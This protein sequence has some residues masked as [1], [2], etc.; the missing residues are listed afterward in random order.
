MSEINEEIIKSGLN[1]ILFSMQKEK[2]A[3]WVE[4]CSREEEYLRQKSREL[5]LSEGDRNT[6]YFHAAA[7][8][9]K[10]N[11][12]IFSIVDHNSGKIINE[13]AE[14]KKVGVNFFKDLLA[15]RN[16]DDSS[17]EDQLSVFLDA[18]PNMISEEDNN[19]LMKPFTMEEIWE[20]VK[21]FPPDKAP[22][23][24]G[25]TALFFQKCW[26][27][28]GWELLLALEVSRKTGS[29]LKEFNA[30]NVAI[31]PKIGDPQS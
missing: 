28:L 29:M 12:V 11:N 18:I 17:S 27:V 10:A 5:W 7:N 6:K 30:T 16:K 23:P 13:E 4:L 25:F 14:I 21:S 1:S 2:Q 8:Q 3:E 24:D 9:R 15:P 31:I 20:V 19:R 22:G 26:D